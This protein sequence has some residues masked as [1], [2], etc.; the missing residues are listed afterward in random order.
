MVV[1]D[2]LGE[3]IDNDLLN[4]THDDAPYLTSVFLTSHID[5]SSNLLAMAM[6]ILDILQELAEGRGFDS[7]RPG[8]QLRTKNNKVLAED[9]PAAPTSGL[10]NIPD[11]LSLRL[12]SLGHCGDSLAAIQEAMKLYRELIRDR[13][14]AFAPDL[15]NSLN[16]LSGRLSNPC[17]H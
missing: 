6:F 4:I 1:I 11:T 15:A 5:S 8:E 13:P 2:A 10:A 12:S 7:D 9:H 16:G 14:A 3:G 17:P